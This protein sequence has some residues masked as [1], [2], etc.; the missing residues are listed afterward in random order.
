MYKLS[1][2]CEHKELINNRI[3]CGV[4][5]INYF[6]DRLICE[7]NSISFH[8]QGKDYDLELKDKENKINIIINEFSTNIYFNGNNIFNFLI[9]NL[10]NANQSNH[11]NIKIINSML[12]LNKN[13]KLILKCSLSEI[14]NIEKVGL[15]NY[16]QDS[17]W[18]C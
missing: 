17:W 8:F 2:K 18:I 12:F 9:P 15:R 13:H 10:V 14:F 1:I 7:N 3:F 16:H 5:Q 4:K 6:Y 11:F